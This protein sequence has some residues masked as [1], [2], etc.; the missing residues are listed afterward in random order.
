MEILKN[1]NALMFLL[2]SGISFL[3]NGMNFI[4]LSWL[5][6]EISNGP[7]AVGILVAIGAIPGILTAPFTGVFADRYNKKKIA[8][9]MDIA[10][11]ITV[12]SIPFV[13]KEETSSLLILYLYSIL[14]AVFNNFFYPAI[15]GMI[16]ECIEEKLFIKVISLN[17]TLQ[18]IGYI[19]GP[20]LG[21][22][23]VS[24]SSFD[25]VFYID[26]VTFFVSGFFLFLLSYKY[27]RTVGNS[28]GTKSNMLKDFTEGLSYLKSTPLLIFLTFFSLV[29][30]SIVYI[31]NSLLSDYTN[32][33]GHGV[34][35]YGLLDTAFGIGSALTGIIITILG[36]KINKNRMI[37]FTYC[38]IAISSVV[39]CFSNSILISFISIGIL[40]ASIMCEGVFRKTL[41]MESVE[42]NYIGRVESLNWVLIS[43]LAPLISIGATILASNTSSRTVFGILFFLMLP[44]IFL[45]HKILYSKYN[46]KTDKDIQS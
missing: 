42:K 32:S 10:R 30:S 8:I 15:S 17:G 4:A 33:M 41:L 45:S 22:L 9:I 20:A 13:I 1:R 2:A 21:G 16:K 26:S 24:V 7:L 6:Y 3:G 12:L 36:A 11:G 34:S 5:T 19:V 35:I 39:I 25:T 28:E 38:G 23:I 44:I 46:H 27:K 29:G 37:P 40:G 18:Q 43:S 31:F 14:L